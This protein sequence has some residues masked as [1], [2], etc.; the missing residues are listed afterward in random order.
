MLR[1]LISIILSVFL[2][3]VVV[4][5][6]NKFDSDHVVVPVAHPSGELHNIAVPED[7][8][9]Q[10][11]H[12]SLLASDYHLLTPETQPTAEGS[13]EHSAEFKNTAKNAWVMGELG[14]K[15][16]EAGTYLDSKG[17]PG[18]LNW[19]DSP[20]GENANVKIT[21]PVDAMGSIHTHPNDR[22]DKPSADDIAIAKRVHKTIFVVSRSGLWSV[23]PSGDT[24]QVFKNPNWMDEKKK[25]VKEK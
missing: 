15:S 11:F 13:I 3:A 7:T 2:G 1:V 8:N 4:A 9:I 18:K 25:S 12:S 5:N 14:R 24:T 22:T 6:E 17:A 21:E 16:G 23:D 10:E 20:R 19:H